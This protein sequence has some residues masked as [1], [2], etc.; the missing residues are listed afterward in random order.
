[1]KNIILFILRKRSKDSN[2]SGHS[3][4]IWLAHD[5]GMFV[6][7][8][9]DCGAALPGGLWDLG[10]NGAGGLQPSLKI[11]CRHHQNF[12][13]T[14]IVVF[15]TATEFHQDSNKVVCVCWAQFMDRSISILM[16]NCKII[17]Q[18][19]KSVLSGL[20]QEPPSQM[21]KTRTSLAQC[22]LRLQQG[23]FRAPV[24]RADAAI[25]WGLPGRLWLPLV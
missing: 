1:M 11:K 14:P 16:T 12:I 22:K 15:Q 8:W 9:A 23:R 10:G 2:I 7:I 24:Q 6:W 5:D 25:P 4:K 17:L 18:D 21:A 20:V 3:W 13:Q 19:F